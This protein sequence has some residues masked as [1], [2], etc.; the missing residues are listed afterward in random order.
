M[1]TALAM[2]APFFY[3]EGF[4]LALGVLVKTYPEDAKSRPWN[5]VAAASVWP[6]SS[7]LS[8]AIAVIQELRKKP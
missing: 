4:F 8:A 6:F 3:L 5:L 1:I 7:P 2:L